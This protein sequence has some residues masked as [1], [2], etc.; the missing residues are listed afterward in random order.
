MAEEVLDLDI[1]R[2]ATKKVKLAGKEIDVSFIP[3][4]ITF[5][6]DSIIRELSGFDEEKIK[7]DETT[8]KRAFDL[9]LNLCS[10]FCSLKHPEMTPDWFRLNTSPEQVNALTNKIKQAL[11]DSYIGVERYGKN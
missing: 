6:V 8:I 9:A 4:G 3:C 1:L 2:P 11:S 7:T 5:E 10:A